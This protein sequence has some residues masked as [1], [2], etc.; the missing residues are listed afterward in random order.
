MGVWKYLVSTIRNDTEGRMICRVFGDLRSTEGP[1]I[2]RNFDSGVVY[3]IV[4][5]SNDVVN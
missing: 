1:R 2:E 4:V 5:I 3:N